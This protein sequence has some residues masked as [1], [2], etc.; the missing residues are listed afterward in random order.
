MNTSNTNSKPNAKTQRIINLLEQTQEALAYLNH[1]DIYA[2]R[3]S[4]DEI[5]IQGVYSP[6]VERRIHA[7]YLVRNDSYVSDDFKRK[8]HVLKTSD[9]QFVLSQ[10][11]TQ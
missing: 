8:F 7:R 10:E 2:I 11:L 3:Y 4:A 9:F 6:D 1:D 5:T